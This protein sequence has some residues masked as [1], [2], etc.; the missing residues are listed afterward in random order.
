M[1]YLTKQIVLDLK[2]GPKP[3]KVSDTVVNGKGVSGLVVRVSPGG[4]KTFAVQFRTREGRKG[5]VPIGRFGIITVDQARD[6][7]KKHLLAVSLG[8]DP[9]KKLREDR[10]AITVAGLVDRFVEEHA[11]SLAP[12]SAAEY[13]R[14]LRKH[15]V[16]ALGSRKAQSIGTGDV[17]ELLGSIRKRTPVE[18]NRLL[19]VT[20]KMFNLAELWEVRDRGT[21]PVVGQVRTNEAARERRMQEP[22]IRALGQIIREVEALA[23]DAKSEEIEG[24]M[25]Q[26]ESPHALAA[27]KLSLLAGFRKGE[28][29]GLRWAWV[30]LEKGVAT[31]PPSAHKT[32]R[33]T[34]KSRVVYLCP[35]AVAILSALP[36]FDGDE[37]AKDYNPHVIVGLRKGAALVQIQDVWE[38]LRTAVTDRAKYEAKEAKKHKKQPT[39]AVAIGDVHLHDLRRTFASVAA[40]LRIPD[41]IVK[42]L[43]GHQSLGSVTEVYTRL[44]VDPIKASADEVGGLI[45]GWL[46]DARRPESVGVSSC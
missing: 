18:A 41:L 25:L 9:A 10:S 16:P 8:Q 39:P 14:L 40:D 23:P 13:E 30:N 17:S 26:P 27:V 2:P 36:R 35:E 24:A 28:I 11:K 37:D 21:N 43:L 34:G 19:A 29:L 33:K 6:E 42:A 7:A 46:L 38:R 20:R 22:E 31:I 44:S 5:W 45:A 3:Y 15:L 1:P 4:T 32:G 12:R